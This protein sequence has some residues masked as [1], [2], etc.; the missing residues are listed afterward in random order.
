M[1]FKHYDSLN[2]KGLNT[3]PYNVNLETIKLTLSVLK[4]NHVAKLLLLGVDKNLAMHPSLLFDSAN[5]VS[6]LLFQYDTLSF[7]KQHP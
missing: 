6:S 5:N 7:N 4:H 3:L 1:E 2:N